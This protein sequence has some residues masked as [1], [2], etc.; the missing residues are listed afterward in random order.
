MSHSSE[1]QKASVP[2][3]GTAQSTPQL[4]TPRRAKQ[5][6]IHSNQPEVSSAG[7]GLSKLI[8]NAVTLTSMQTSPKIL[9]KDAILAHTSIE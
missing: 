6:M 2:V 7:E 8:L 4:E 5:L 9:N 1:S 3:L